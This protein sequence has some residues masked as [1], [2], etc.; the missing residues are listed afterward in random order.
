MKVK[1]LTACMLAGAMALSVALTGC[2]KI[3]AN[4]VGATLDGKEISLGFMNFMARYQQMNYDASMS[5]YAAYYG[6]EYS[7]EYWSQTAG[8][9]EKDDD[10]NVTKP[11]QTMEESVKEEVAENIELLYLLE[12]HLADYNVEITDEETTAIEE[13]A[14]KFMADN[15][16]K[17]I[18]QMGATE[19]YVKEMLRLL[20]IQQKVK[21]AVYDA[22]TA[23]VTDEEA[24][25]RTYSYFRVSTTS[26]TDSSGNSV[27]LTDEEKEQL[28]SDM[29]QVAAA[30]KEDFEGTAKEKGYTVSTQSYGADNTLDEKL[31]AAADA[32]KEGEVSDLITTDTY[33]YVIRLDK[34]YDE[35][36]TAQKKES[37]L[38]TKKQEEFD[39]ICD[40]YKKDV[41]FEVNEKEWAKVKFDR[42]FSV[43]SEEE[44]KN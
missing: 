37:L 9:E 30:A 35:E 16:K 8:E 5:Y 1:R 20:T 12:A 7:I 39:S 22:S 23:T 32:L 6:S 24:A 15:S 36:A 13:A 25:Q 43:A 34:E 4:A 41:K 10:G 26:T 40:G 31:V 29:A 27:D 33:Y 28:A 11:A 17:A 44:T 38:A 21:D 3:D 19:E 42:L 14:K 18:R 2:G